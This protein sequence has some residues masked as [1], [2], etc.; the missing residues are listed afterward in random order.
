MLGLPQRNQHFSSIMNGQTMKMMNQTSDYLIHFSELAIRY[1]L[2]IFGA[3]LIF[4]IGWMIAG[5]LKRWTI[6][7]LSRI[8][9]MDQTIVRFFGGIVRYG[10]LIIVLVMVL[11]QFGVQTASILAALGAIGIAIGLALQG[12]LQNIAAGIMLLIL[13]PF[14]VGETI[15]AGPVVGTVQE[16]GLFTT[17]LQTYDGLYVSSPNALLWNTQVINS[18]RLETRMHDFK[19][20]IAYEDDIDKA[21]SILKEV[22]NAQDSVLKAP[23]PNYF[24]AELGD[25]AVILCCRYWVKNSEYWTVARNTTKMVKIAFDKAGIS[26]PYPQMTNRLV[27]AAKQPEPK[28]K[29]G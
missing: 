17:E 4:V 6:N 28:S 11:G 18:S 10:M 19:V 27:E 20:G 9:G 12:T 24:V 29:L 3:L 7:S 21:I 13:R 22:V 2:S 15:T 8:K 5:F 25:S 26:I 23:E 16:I 14:R 1:S